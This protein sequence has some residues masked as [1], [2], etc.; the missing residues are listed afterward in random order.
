MW[1]HKQGELVGAYR[2]GRVD[3]LLGHYGAEGLYTS[4]LFNFQPQLLER[5]HNALELGRSFIRP[6]YQRSYAPLL[7]LWKGIGHY[8]VN[9]PHY[10]YLFGPVSISNDYTANSRHLMV[11]TLTTLLHG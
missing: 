5:L 3:D 8:L 11:D 10:R 9:N 7:L 6:E 4:T 2:I 1:N